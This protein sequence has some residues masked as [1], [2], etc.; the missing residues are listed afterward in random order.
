MQHN[1]E[2][3]NRLRDAFRKKNLTLYLGAGVSIGSKLPSWEKLVLAM[4][5]NKISQER[6]GGWRPFSNYLYA[7]AEWHLANSPEPLEITARKLKK[8][9]KSDLMNLFKDDLYST[10]YGGFLTNGHPDPI[11]QSG[12]LRENNSTLDSVA[13]LCKSSNG[14][15]KAVI[16]YNYD[17]LLEIALHDS[18]LPVFRSVS[19]DPNLLPIYHVHGFVPLDKSIESSKGEDIIFTEDQYHEVAENPYSW[20]NLVQLQL[21]SNSVGLMIGLSLSDTNMRRLLDAVRNS[22]IQSVNFALLQEP[23]TS[24]P[25]EKEIDEIHKSAINYLEDFQ[26]SGIKEQSEYNGIL[27]PRPGAKSDYPRQLRVG[28]KTAKKM[29]R[30]GKKLKR[31][32]YEILG[33]IREVKRIDREQQEDV[34]EQLGITPIWF[35]EFSEIPI[36]ISKIIS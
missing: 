28:M 36:I 5:F 18:Y 34:L 15:V 27:F 7:I 24:P 33:I 8:Y 9:Y 35:K 2:S 26:R 31:Y 29:S 16:T 32:Q 22:P 19:L 4:Y 3:I 17:S 12:Y 23:D 21:M 30:G 25:N 20:S 13:R 10:L 14:G 6:M 11:I 1:E